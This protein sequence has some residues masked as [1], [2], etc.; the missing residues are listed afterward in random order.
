MEP[1][2]TG[3]EALHGVAWLG[4]ATVFPQA[5]GLGAT[6]DTGLVERVGD[7]TG[8]EM[9]GFNAQDPA[10]HG[11][12]VWAP[13]VDP[14][15]DPR[16]GRNEE[17]Y[18][19][20][21]LLVGEMATAYTGG[22]RGDDDFYLKTAPS[23]KH[24]AGYNIEEKRDRLSVTVPPRALNEYVYPSFRP[25]IEAGNATGVMASYNLVNGRPAHL[26]PLL[27][28][29]RSWSDEDLMVVS[30][31][32]A[33]SN[34]VETQGYYD[35]H[36]ESHAA[37]LKAGI[38]SYTDQGEDSSV[39]V[40]RFTDALD[41]GLIG[42]EDLDQA[43]GRILSVRFRLGEFDPPDR[44]PY[45]DITPDVIDSPEHRELAREAATSQMTLLRND[46]ALPLDAGS[47]TDVAVV[48][49]LADT[50]YEDWYS[51]TMPYRSTPA[52]GIA[53][54]LGDAGS[55]GVSDG[56]DR[57]ALKADGGYVTASGDEDGGVLRVGDGEGD[58]RSL[59]VFDWGEGVV[60]LRTDANGKVVGLGE[61]N[62]LY[63]DQD[64]PNG[65][66]VQQLFRFEEVDGGVALKYAGYDE[67]NRKYIAVD[68]EGRLSVSA[69]AVEDAAVF[70][71]E[72]LSSGAEEAVEAASGADAAV[73]VLGNMPF[74]NGR[75]TDDREEIELPPAQQELLEAV[76]EANPN[77]V[78][79]VESSYPMAVPWAEE[80]V[81]AVL[82]TSHAG[83]ET[84]NALASVLYGDAEP[85]G[86]LPQT[87]Y[88]AT[89]D[90]PD[91][92][93]YDVQH[94]GHTYRHF[95]GEALYPFGHG[96]SYTSFEYGKPKADRRKVGPDGTVTVEVPVTNTGGRDGEEVVQLY[97]R[98]LDSRTEQPLK[99]LRD[100]A[101]VSVPAGETVTAELTV[102]A[103]DLGFWDVTRGEWA[104]E[105][106]KH[107]L[108]VGASA[109]DIRHRMKIKVKGER[110]PA[111][112]L[113]GRT[114][115][116]DF[117]RYS[118]VALADETKVEGDTVEAD[119]G[120]WIA[121]DGTD[122]SS[123]PSVFTAR[124][125]AASGGAAVEVRVGAPDGRKIGE[126]AIGATG[127][128]YDYEEFTGDLGKAPGGK[129]KDVYL[130]FT[131]E[132]RLSSF[133]L[134]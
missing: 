97:S 37:M 78:L 14:L 93:D 120:D 59:T 3:T 98:Q 102:D 83:Q 90:L 73:V 76:T 2:R 92:G 117:D 128:V 60:T 82:W 57:I 8:T 15:R 50:L 114:R 94:S 116:A 7:V 28:D 113:T 12:N 63:N 75:E 122:L 29:V 48:G 33:P 79:V 46:G 58:A 89:G 43:V 49:P 4:E 32:F 30:D 36:A 54:R 42:E 10:A 86:R 26:T 44:V 131:G 100:F 87:W 125:A 22:L 6:W 52:D 133:S 111:R 16:W 19:E 84:G 27:D 104:V 68:G 123:K 53:D 34:V 118:G 39:T 134:E 112:D 24:F 40:G 51:G 108:M 130:V 132:V 62:R 35:D 127:G 67:W 13:V 41:Q 110:I 88:R 18:S 17:G 81:P 85:Q 126:A 11:L 20:E 96:L 47:D 66:F 1:F 69:D 80:N 71:R 38:D 101:R 70:E 106:A 21:P 115:A 9:R 121:F 56:A 119:A 64:Q 65:W 23:L 91:M 107:E 95:E 105:K 5:V 109:D 45:S 99:Q 25:A 72:V 129:K 103:A 124:A 31:A 74:I 77:T 55:V 61:G